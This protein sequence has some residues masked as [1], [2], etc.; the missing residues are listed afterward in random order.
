MVSW[1]LDRYG[2][3]D[4]DGD[5]RALEL[6]P[7]EE[8]AAVAGF[9]ARLRPDVLAVQEIG[10][11]A[12]LAD[13]TRSLET[14]RLR[15]DH[16]EY[17]RRGDSELHL[18][19]LSRFPIVTR[20]SRVDDRYRIGDSEFAVE[21]GML[22]VEI[23]PAPGYR[24]RLLVARLKDKVFHPASQ[25]EMRRN[26]ARLLGNHV[27]R[28]L[29]ASP[30]ANL[31]VAGDFC[32]TWDSAPLREIVGERREHLEDLRPVDLFGAAWTWHNRADDLCERRDYLL[33]SR[34]LK[35]E[36]V[37]ARSRTAADREAMAASSHRPLIAVIRAAEHP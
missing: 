28:I 37:A 33:A 16:S 17:V 25:T 20:Q 8:R 19:V 10:N 15:Y 26:E 23:E 12:A 13:F 29:R 1:N 32:D 22:D 27:R 14:R 3:S 36:I 18:A 7:A 2:P 35:P 5:G 21:S 4:R 24:V 11:P 31:L 30:E 9:L 6:K 34:G